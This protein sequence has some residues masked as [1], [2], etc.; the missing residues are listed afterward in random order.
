VNDHVRRVNECLAGHEYGLAQQTVYEMWMNEICAVYMELVK[1]VV[2]DT[3]EE[4]S[5]KRNVAQGTLWACLEIGLRLL[6]PMMPFI[7]EELWQRLPGRGKLGESETQTIMLAEYPQHLA[8]YDNSEV[9]GDMEVAMEAVK[10][11]RSLKKQYS[12][13]N[14]EK[15]TFFLKSSKYERALKN[16][17]DDIV[18]LGGG[19]VKVNETAPE[20]SAIVV[21]NEDLTVFIDLAGLVDFDKE[22]AKVSEPEYESLKC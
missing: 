4:N 22:I 17:A 14:K 21:A 6:H 13:A 18:T 3:S 15:P 9:E 20:T 12:I 19:V 8:K 16:H 2:Y 10:A 1:P 11:C 5:E 7:T